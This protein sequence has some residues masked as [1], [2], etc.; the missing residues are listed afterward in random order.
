MDYL[1]LTLALAVACFAG[2][3]FFYLMFLQATNRQQQRRISELERELMELR[4]VRG[5]AA[6]TNSAATETEEVWSELIDD[7]G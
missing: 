6:H 7:A 2:V 3:Q 5:G 1:V 4:R